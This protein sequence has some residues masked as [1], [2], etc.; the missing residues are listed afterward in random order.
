VLVLQNLHLI[1]KQEKE[2]EEEEREK[3]RE[4]EIE[5]TRRDIACEYICFG[6]S[7]MRKGAS[8]VQ[9]SLS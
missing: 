8:H 6:R 9:K 7:L 1:A 3:E 2:E 5:R 4:N